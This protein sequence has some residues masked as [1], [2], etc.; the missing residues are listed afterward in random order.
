MR[1]LYNIGYMIGA[2]SGLPAILAGVVLSDKRRKTFFKRLGLSSVPERIRNRYY[3]R[4][5][6]RTIWVHALS[7]GEVLSAISFISALKSAFYDRKIILSVSTASGYEIAHQHLKDVVDCLFFFPYDLIFS[8]NY[9][10]RR[11]DPELVLIVESDIWPNFPAEMK[12]RGIPVCWINA[13]VSDSSFR[14][15][16]RLP[17]IARHLFAPF[18]KICTQSRDDAQRLIALGIQ[19]DRIVSVGNMKFDQPVEPVADER[20]T[21]IKCKFR[22]E[23][24]RRILLAGSTHKGEEAILSRAFSALKQTIPDLLLIVVPR[25]PERFK[26]VFHLFESDGF[27]A[28]LWTAPPRDT[29]A[30]VLVVDAMGE[31]RQL[32]ALADI[33]FVGGSLMPF[34]GHNPLEPAGFSKPVLFGPYM[35]DFALISKLLLDSGAAVRVTDAES[36]AAT[37]AEL[38]ADEERRHRIGEKAFSVVCANQGAVQRTLSAVGDTLMK[39]PFRTGASCSE[40]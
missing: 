36:L 18:E 11:I 21:A 24:Q 7:V 16:K 40:P 22:I 31:L 10:S 23:P 38:M 5:A 39:T 4:A 15:Y 12:R 19:P 8:V 29:K 26:S 28:A 37:V 20:L 27:A 34:G 6:H 33:A 17:A 13:R 9:I 14:S 3:R 35:N 30:D 25:N 2:I 32:Y 1:L